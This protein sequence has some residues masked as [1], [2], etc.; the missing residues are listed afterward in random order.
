MHVLKGALLIL[1]T[2]LAELAVQL[3]LVAA[4]ATEQAGHPMSGHHLLKWL[5]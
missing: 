1:S 3:S 5:L 2:A 4:I